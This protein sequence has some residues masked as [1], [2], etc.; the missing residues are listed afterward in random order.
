MAAVAASVTE[1]GGDKFRGITGD[2]LTQ[3]PVGQSKASLN[4]VVFVLG[5][6]E[7]HQVP[8]KNQALSSDSLTQSL[9]K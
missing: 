2:E 6:T 8:P 5:L 4:T 3:C 1:Q 9:G 7:L